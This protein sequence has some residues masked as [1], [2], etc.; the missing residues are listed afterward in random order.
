MRHQPIVV[1][2]VVL[3]T[4]SAPALALGLGEPH[5][6]AVL[7]HP[8]DV[9]LPITGDGAD[10]LQPGCVEVHVYVGENRVPK[11]QVKTALER[12]SPTANDTVLHLR[13]TQSVDE[14]VVQLDVTIG[15][16]GRLNRQFTLL[17]DPP[18]FDVPANLPQV[19]ATASP[20]ADAPVATA[21]LPPMPATRRG[22][23][24]PTTRADIEPP[25]QR[26]R[27]PRQRPPRPVRSETVA[28]AP[29]ASS[30]RQQAAPRVARAAAPAASGPRR[31]P[32]LSMEAP[33][34]L[35][36][37]AAGLPVAAA[38]AATPASAPVVVEALV[39]ASAPAAGPGDAGHQMADALAK[40]KAESQ[41][42]REALVRLEAQLAQ[43]DNGHALL[44]APAWITVSGLLALVAAGLAWRLREQRRRY[45]HGWWDSGSRIPAR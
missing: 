42:Q 31:G 28:T 30:A 9:R 16:Q 38:V 23:A 26:V 41:A 43:R 25:P 10:A 40:L 11:E 19:V 18:R 8:I 32:R 14:P 35:L 21:E 4:A 34:V 17:P 13:T 2:A 12:V 1:A 20:V 39:A 22:T 15:C 37:A 36:K 3:A 33:Q 45:E 29:A 24:L 27:A 5:T 7:G 44:N 6:N